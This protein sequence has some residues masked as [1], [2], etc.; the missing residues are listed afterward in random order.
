M[1]LVA[2]PRAGPACRWPDPAR[3]APPKRSP[4][5]CV[6]GRTARGSAP[7]RLAAAACHRWASAKSSSAA[8]WHPDLQFHYPTSIVDIHTCIANCSPFILQF[9]RTKN[10]QYL[11]SS[12]TDS[13]LHKY[14]RI[15]YLG[16]AMGTARP[17]SS[18]GKVIEPTMDG[19]GDRLWIH[20]RSSEDELLAAACS[21]Q[22]VGVV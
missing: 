10:I 8:V 9:P 13:R 7:P 3:V 15:L 19:F 14:S 2:P 11:V 1:I 20:V 5:A 12:H 21:R 18:R 4:F 6:P 22:R 17:S 16:T